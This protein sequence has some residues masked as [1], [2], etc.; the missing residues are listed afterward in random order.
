ML[1][2][3]A[4]V[5]LVLLAAVVIWGY[6]TDSRPYVVVS[7]SMRP[8][9]EVGDALV[10]RPVDVVDVGDV[11]TFTQQGHVVTHRVTS[12]RESGYETK[13]DANPSADPGIVSPD[14]VVGTAVARVPWAGYALVYLQQPSGIASL[15]VLPL[16]VGQGWRLAGAISSPAPRRSREAVAPPPARAR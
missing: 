2:G 6:G 14:A 13:G 10:V 12:I 5:T 8:T 15:A 16:V 3:S 9:I 7:G 1:V 4:T 11:L